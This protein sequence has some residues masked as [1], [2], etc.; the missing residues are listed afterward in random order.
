MTH[1]LDIR[2][3]RLS[4]T[5]TRRGGDVNPQEKYSEYPNIFLKVVANVEENEREL[6]H[7]PSPLLCVYQSNHWCSEREAEA[8][9][10]YPIYPQRFYGFVNKAMVIYPDDIE[11]WQFANHAVEKALDSG[12]HILDHNH[13]LVW[14]DEMVPLDQEV[15]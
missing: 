14:P 1:Q 3:A 6:A 9:V 8:W 12:A 7:Y 4:V 13:Y 15:E 10:V 2:L 11:Y 5:T